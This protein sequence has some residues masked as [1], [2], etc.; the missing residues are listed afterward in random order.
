ML[1]TTTLPSSPRRVASGSVRYACRMLE[2]GLAADWRNVA[3][4]EQRR[5]GR[6]RL[7]RAVRVPEL[8][9][10]L[11]EHAPVRPVHEAAVALG[12]RV[13]EIDE[14]RVEAILAP[15]RVDGRLERTEAPAER[16]LR[17]VGEPLSVEDEH[18][19]LLEG[20]E[21]LLEPRRVERLSEINALD[22]GAEAGMDRSDRHPTRRLRHGRA[23]LGC[24][25][26]EAPRARQ[27]GSEHGRSWAV[28]SGT[29]FGYLWD[30]HREPGSRT[31]R[32]GR[33]VWEPYRVES[34]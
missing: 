5:H 2:L 17:L 14:V 30:A 25:I 33:N 16:Y 23:S 29:G 6:H 32:P 11:V 24:S 9:A 34:G 27:G 12:I 21:D 7:E 4:G 19:I 28:A 13:R 26:G 18:G 31:P 20:V 10:R 15:G 1:C 22:A 3:A 8:V